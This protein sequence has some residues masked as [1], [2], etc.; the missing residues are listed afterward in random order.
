MRI[1]KSIFLGACFAFPA[2]M[3]AEST[4]KSSDANGF[5]ARGIKMYEAKNYVG[6]IDQ[7]KH[8]LS[9]QTIP[10]LQ[11]EAEY[12]IALSEYER[13]K[14]HSVSLLK[15]FIAQHPSSHRVPSVN[16]TIG[17]YYFFNGKFGEAILSYDKAAKPNGLDLDK[18]EDV[19]YR[20]AFS[21]LRLGNYANAKTDFDRLALKSKRYS[22]ATAFYN[23]YIDYA[24]GDLKSARERFA[25]IKKTGVLGYHAQYYVC[26]ID[27]AESKFQNAST[28]AK[29]LLA[30]GNFDY[31]NS[32]LNRIVGESEYQL[33]NDDTAEKYL[34]KYITS[35]SDA[36]RRSAEYALGVIKY[37]KSDYDNA[38]ANMSRV[39]N[40]NDKLAQSAYLYL[41]QS[42]LKR[43]ELNN[44]SMSFEKA[45][46]MDYD[47]TVTETAFYNYAITQNDGGRTPFNRSIDIFER[48]INQYPNS[49]YADNVE[50]YLVNAYTTSNDYTKALTSISHITKPSAKVLKAKQ[51]VL[52]NLGM[53]AI[54]NSATATA[55]DYFTQ[56]INVGNYDSKI[57]NES[58]LWLG[59]CLYR[60]GSYASAAAHFTNFINNAKKN[61]ANLPLA[62]YNLG[63]ALFQQQKYSNAAT[64]FKT[65]TTAKALSSEVRADAFSR[66]GDT[67]YYTKQYSN[68]IANYD[69]AYELNPNAGDYPMFQK[70]VMLGLTK[71]HS[72]KIAQIDKM[73]ATFPQSTLAPAALLEK[74]N[75]YEAMNKSESAIETYGQ[76]VKNYPASVE[77]RKG[78]LQLALAEKQLGNESKAISAYK[79][80][81]STYPTS[82]EAQVATEDLKLI[83]ADQGNL[84]DLAT[85]LGKVPNAPKFEVSEIDRLTFE[86]AE[87]AALAEKPSFTKMESYI[88]KFPNGAYVANAN[89]YMARHNY[90]EGNYEKALSNLNSALVKIDASFSEDA[91]AMKSDI[92]LRQKKYDAALQS[93]QALKEKASTADNKIIANLG[94]MRVATA[95]SI[96]DWIMVK[97]AATEILSESGLT[98]TEETEATYGLALANAN[99]GNNNEAKAELKKLAQTPSN[100]FGARAAVQLAKMQYD[101][102]DYKAA[103]ATCNNLIDAGTP[104]QYW[105]AKAFIQLADVYHKQGKDF[106]A[107]EYLESLKSNYPGKESDIF[108]DI[109]QRLSSWKATKNTTKKAKK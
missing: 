39:A 66:L 33:G 11:E 87:K 67:N 76:I 82:E 43:N 50:E 74:G 41:G 56:A 36:P 109:D 3:L 16:A 95:Q 88:Q 58:R 25:K 57:L 105:L 91:L 32:E 99:L 97:K 79:Q 6:A 7:L 72:A 64:Y 51:Y 68:A 35:S 30:D 19:E 37:R 100:E 23:A 75:A 83:Y 59:E 1:I 86:A 26:Q 61:D 62:N 31:F 63:Y 55:K 24:K 81:I 49:R 77:A 53:Q 4:D 89:Y 69:K 71:Q 80:I 13:N 52:Y 102:G 84:H 85:F 65:A 42:Y 103:E 9:T 73:I 27:F 93:Y 45:L 40:A 5:M 38:I 106:E 8:S 20:R 18:Q 101:N 15:E 92:L 2:I 48:F 96:V 108:N 17:D 46:K 94:I 98:A 104:H 44:A 78:L 21:H 54:E 29:S 90:Q 60:N 70:A 28:L 107:C 47:R 10:A 22:E 34:E 12:Y 14:S